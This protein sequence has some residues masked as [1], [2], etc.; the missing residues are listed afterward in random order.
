MI[1]KIDHIGLAVSNLDDFLD[2]FNK[3]FGTRAE[4]TETKAL[5]AGFIQ[6]GDIIIEPIQPLDKDQAIGQYIS[7]HGNGIHHIC[8]EVDDI[9]K[10]LDTLAAKG[11]KLNDRK[12]RPGLLGKVGFIN[13][14]STGDV[15]IELVE[16][17]K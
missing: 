3:L 6:V 14:T 15:I 7:K 5:K 10:E 13:P 17:N 11:V 8:F 9:D 2:I 1:K 16:K 12:G 4:V